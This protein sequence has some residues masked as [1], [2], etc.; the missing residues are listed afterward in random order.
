MIHRGN[1]HFPVIIRKGNQLTDF[2]H[3]EIYS[4]EQHPGQLFSVHVTII[5]N[6]RG[7]RKNFCFD[8]SMILIIVVARV[9]SISN[10]DDIILNLIRESNL[11]CYLM[12]KKVIII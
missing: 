8:D 1:H 11:S 2:D 9:F 5:F 3:L 12:L 7:I 4:Q 10:N 6:L